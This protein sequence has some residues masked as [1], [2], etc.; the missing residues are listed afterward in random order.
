MAK[1]TNKAE[2]V[3]FAFSRYET[4]LRE[5]RKRVATYASFAD[6]KTPREAEIYFQLHPEVL[7]VRKGVY[8]SP[9]AAETHE[10]CDHNDEST[11]A[12]H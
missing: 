3:S 9:S 6:C 11:D 8:V 5:E 12:V 7:S 1:A 2:R 10:E 4:T